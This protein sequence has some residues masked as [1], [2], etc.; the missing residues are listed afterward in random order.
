MGLDK[1]MNNR[2][3]LGLSWKNQPNLATF[4][5]RKFCTWPGTKFGASCGMANAQM[6]EKK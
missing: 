3:K 2:S 4:A 6:K 5:A 1:T